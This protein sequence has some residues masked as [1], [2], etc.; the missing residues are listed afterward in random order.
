MA[1]PSV[2]P[3]IPVVETL[4]AMLGPNYEIV[5]HDFTDTEHS[6][7]KIANGH[8]TGREVGAPATDLILA[9][10]GKTTPT[11]KIIGYRTRARNGAELRS[12]TVF[13][14]DA[15]G[16]VVGALCLNL[17]LTPYLSMRHSLDEV[18]PQSPPQGSDNGAPPPETFESNVSN[19]IEGLI[20]QTIGAIGRPIPRMNREDKVRAIQ[21]LKQRGIFKMRGSARR[22]SRKLNVS[23][24]TVYK[25]LQ[26][27]DEE[28]TG[29]PVPQRSAPGK[30]CGPGILPSRRR[31]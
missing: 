10:A 20:D 14:K 21:E 8:I 3:F 15:K 24:A 22:V 29:A 25:Y 28:G 31:I 9:H 11:D 4:A 5:L 19:L 17:D 1:H 30:S 26:E 13:I 23:L 16:R 2:K 12:S 6:I 18:L 27:G 7:I